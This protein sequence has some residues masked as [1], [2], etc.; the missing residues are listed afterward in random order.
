MKVFVTGATG[1]IG[2]AVVKELQS[3]GHQ[4]IGL[5][6]SDKTAELLKKMGADVHRGSLEDLESL[7]EGAT[8]ADGVIHLAFDNNSFDDFEK[9]L[10]TDQVAI[11]TIGKALAGSGK[12][13]V[14]TSVTTMLTTDG[15]PS[16]EDMSAVE[17][18][19]GFP[20]SGAENK[21]ISLAQQGVRSVAVRLAPCVHDNTSQGFATALSY[22]AREKGISAY[23]NDGLNHWPA[24]HRNDVASLFRLALESAP[25]G[26]TLH[27]V[28]EEGILFRDIAKA[29][30]DKFNL[31]VESISNETVGEHFGWLTTFVT[32]D[33]FVSS[34]KTQEL[35]NWQPKGA[36]LITDIENS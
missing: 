34:K 19:P 28:G 32:F 7:T 35:L 30:G 16:T 1:F 18:T 24:I 36:S 2:T 23:A 27:G 5:A 26:T 14:S 12:P 15:T 22:L 17:G 3:N 13:F 20:R 6:R 29:I 10:I 31:P 21:V 8:A 4:V 33:N 25:A 11:E 9:I